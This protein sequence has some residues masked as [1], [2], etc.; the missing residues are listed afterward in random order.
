MK[1][2]VLMFA[3]M[4][5]VVS[6]LAQM[7]PLADE[8][9]SSSWALTNAVATQYIFRG[10]RAGGLAY[11][12]SLEYDAGRLGLGVWASVPIKDKVVG[13]SGPEFDFYGFYSMEVAKDLSAVPGFTLYSYTNAK[14]SAG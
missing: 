14:K 1:K 3:A 12:P 6:L 10:V 5:P 2:S 8:E 13:R 7:T 11:Q 9:I 4:L